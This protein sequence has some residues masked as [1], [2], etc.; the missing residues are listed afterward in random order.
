MPAS[1][2]VEE[3][4]K[5][6]PADRIKR[7]KSLR[8]EIEKESELLEEESKKE[9]TD[10][11]EFL[12]TLLKEQ[13]EQE[14][15]KREQQERKASKLEEMIKNTQPSEK[16]PPENSV[17]YGK[18][19]EAVDTKYQPSFEITGKDLVENQLHANSLYESKTDYKF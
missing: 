9:L 16:K 5:L 19:V 11:Q 15:K 14:R 1:F 3:L 2:D 7:I 18:G 6:P 17:T 4:K 12:E 8:E 10:E 13:A